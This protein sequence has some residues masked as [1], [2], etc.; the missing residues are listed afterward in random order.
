MTNK[1]WLIGFGRTL[2]AVVLSTGMMATGCG[3]D[4]TTTDTPDAMVDETPDAGPT[5]DAMC[6]P[7]HGGGCG[8]S[9]FDL[10]LE[11]GEIRLELFQQGPDNGGNRLAAQAFFFNAQTPGIRPMVGTQIVDEN[12][13]FHGCFAYKDGEYYN[14]GANPRHQEI[15][16][17]RAYI[18][19]GA[20]V[21]L[22]NVADDT[23]TLELAKD[24][25]GTAV[26]PSN[27]IQHD[28]LYVGDE[29]YDPAR[30]AFYSWEIAGAGDYLAIDLV[31]GYS[32]ATQM[33]VP[34]GFEPN[35]YFPQEFTLSDPVEADYFASGVSFNKGEPLTITW[36][37]AG[38]EDATSPGVVSFVGFVTANDEVESWCLTPGDSGS[39]T[40]PPE[41]LDY[42]SPEGKLLVGKFA[43]T[44]WEQ[45]QDDARF[46][47]LAVNCKLG[48]Y[49]IT[50]PA[51]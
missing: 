8:D 48:A 3:D 6:E 21:T 39:A 28:I 29:N 14:N 27:R 11:G 45:T 40:V 16:D 46:D 51:Q 30:A 35:I 5:A 2:G 13:D 33:P 50:D 32:A 22:T 42:V 10:A 31:N 25:S 18:D 44:A 26:D 37:N 24:D 20:T 36:D 12:G 9:S 7:G 15:A 34:D 17:S 49:T 43:H 38:E 4:T 41:V 47:V 1:N 19:V 23:D